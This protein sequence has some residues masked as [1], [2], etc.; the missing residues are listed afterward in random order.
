MNINTNVD[1]NNIADTVR[2]AFNFKIGK[3]KLYGVDNMP[4]PLMGLFRE[5]TYQYVGKT[6]VTER[7]EPHTTDDVIALCESAASAFEGE[8]TL[9]CHWNNGHYVSIAPTEDYRQNI[10]GTQD[11]IFPRVLIRA[12]Y[13]GKSFQ[14]SLGYYRDVC[15]NMAMLDSVS[16]CCVNIKHTHSLRAKLDDLIGDMRGLSEGWDN[17]TNVIQRMETRDVNLAKFLADVYGEPEKDSKRSASVHRNRGE[18][19]YNR[20]YSER[21]ATGRPNLAGRD[22]HVSAWEAYNAVQGYAQHDASRKRK[23]SH[24]DR[25]LLGLNDRYVSIAETLALAS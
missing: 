8:V 18:A 24:F 4:T 17:L 25:M 21:I 3:Y 20:I 10:F 6:S 9:K 11:N 22:P 2:S 5:D 16:S 14:A 7:Y 15:R 13:A 1:S 12:G 23:P 19:I